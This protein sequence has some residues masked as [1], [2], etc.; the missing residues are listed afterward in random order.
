MNERLLKWF[1]GELEDD[2]LTDDELAELQGLVFDAV[3]QKILARPGVHSF[4]E[5]PTLQ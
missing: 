3:T 1:H 2:E 4:A 5:H